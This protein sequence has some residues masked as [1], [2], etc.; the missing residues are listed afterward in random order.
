MT[1]QALG[2]FLHRV[3]WLTAFFGVL[4]FVSYFWLDGS[5]SAFGFLLGALGSFGNLLLFEWLSRAIAPGDAPRQ[6][7]KT[8]AFV[9]RYIL[10][11]TIGY[12]IVKGLGVKP[13]AVVLGL[14]A[15]TAAVLL[16]STVEL[17]RSFSESKRAQ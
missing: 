10:L 16:S 3:R 4:G 11:F 6:P 8:G 15:S 9:G 5:R 7:W 12:V 2:R 14:L 17:V 13:L 1:D